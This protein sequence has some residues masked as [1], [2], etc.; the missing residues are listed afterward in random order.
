MLDVEAHRPRR[1][2]MVHAFG[3]PATFELATHEPPPPGAGQVLVDVA[4]AG[5]SFVDVLTARGLYQIKPDLPF[6][7]G[8]E[9]AGTITAVGAGVSPRRIGER[10]C[11]LT[12]GGA[13]AHAAIVDSAEARPIPDGMTFIEASILLASYT[14]SYHALTQRGALKAGETLLVLGAGGAIGYAACEIGKALGAFVVASASTAEKRELALRGG[15]DVA[16]DSSSD[17]WRDDVKAAVGGR[18]IDVIVDPVGDAMTERAFRTLGRNGRLLV[19]GFA[20]GGIA[21]LPANLALLKNA[22]M[23]GVNIRD[24]EKHERS[25]YEAN[26][27]DIFEL[28]ARG[29]LRPP[30]GCVYPLANFAE[31]MGDAGGGATAGRIVVTMDQ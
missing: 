17:S 6:T 2:V 10:V 20:A 30:V 8:S 26:I 21:K 11:A 5:V 28:Y 23:I 22:A 13:L 4:A 24:F 25:L 1:S 12:D 14:T 3:D 7:P 31:A 29:K 16:V 27:A 9:F 19:I 18:A 15:A